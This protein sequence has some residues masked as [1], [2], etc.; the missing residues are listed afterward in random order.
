MEGNLIV[1]RPE[2][3]SVLDFLIKHWNS[4]VLYDI[5]AVP[6]NVTKCG[7]K[8]LDEIR[9]ICRLDS[10]EKPRLTCLQRLMSIRG[11]EESVKL[12]RLAQ[13]WFVIGPMTLATWMEHDRWLEK[14]WYDEET[15][16]TKM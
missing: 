12:L 1:R 7:D 16:I 6:K 5:H 14:P 9:Q 11:G 4:C 13:A 3:Q 2:T 15:L 8:K 10:N